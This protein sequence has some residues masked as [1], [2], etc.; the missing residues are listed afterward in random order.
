[1]PACR[2]VISRD[3]AGLGPPRRGPGGRRTRPRG[4]EAAASTSTLGSKRRP[5]RWPRRDRRRRRPGDP[6]AGPGPRG[7]DEDR[8]AEGVDR[9]TDRRRVAAPS[10][11]RTSV[12]GHQRKSGGRE[13]ELHELLVHADRWT[14][15]A[16][17]D[18]PDAG[19]L[20]QAL[21]GAV[22]AP[23]AVQQRE[24]HVDLAERPGTLAGLGDHEAR[25]RSVPA[26]P[27]GRRVDR[28]QLAGRSER[29]PLGLVDSSTQRPSAVI[30]T[31]I[32]SYP[33][34]SRAAITLPAVTQEMRV[35]AGTAAEDDGDA[36]LAGRSA[37]VRGARPAIGRGDLHVAARQL[38]WPHAPRHASRRTRGRPPRE[39]DAAAQ[40]ADHDGRDVRR[41]WRPRVRPLR[42]TR[43]GRPSRRRS[44]RSR[45]VGPDVR[46]RARRG[47]HAC[48]TWSA[49]GQRSSRR[50][51][52][53]TAR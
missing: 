53:T 49:R 11:G 37:A 20:E 24:D 45:A 23:G 32:T 34:G 52:P 2:R 5:P 6:E 35:L 15:H 16:S 41:R 10:R 40:P 8:V 19:H 3:R 12:V 47:R 9:L 21:D 25:V 44:A 1:M 27:R 29:E 36:G 22:L 13:H 43:P 39:P 38:R 50:G 51:T 4:S 7:L 14:Q 33:R 30:P 42:A 17:A 18:V 31:G 46:V 26:P 28:R 48:S